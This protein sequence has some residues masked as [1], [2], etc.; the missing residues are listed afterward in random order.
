MYEATTF[1]KIL[2]QV[3]EAQEN[4]CNY[5][6]L[7]PIPPGTKEAMNYLYNHVFYLESIAKLIKVS[8]FIEH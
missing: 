2:L 3:L 7:L 8:S 6:L 4:K 1:S 5:L